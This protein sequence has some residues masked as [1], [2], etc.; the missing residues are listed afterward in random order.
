MP[1][2]RVTDRGHFHGGH[3]HAPGDVV[4]LP[5]ELG[6]YFVAGGEL[7]EDGGDPLPDELP[8]DVEG[9]VRLVDRLAGEAERPGD[10]PDAT[11]K[12]GRRKKRGPS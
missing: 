11:P 2:F 7:V 10:P 3:S 4:E 8:R 9:L 12:P 1:L 6:L 5:V